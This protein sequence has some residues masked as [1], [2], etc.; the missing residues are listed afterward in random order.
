MTAIQIEHHYQQPEFPLSNTDM[1][2]Q[3]ESS[4]PHPVVKASQNTFAVDTSIRLLWAVHMC[5]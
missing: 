4:S 5:I 2:P 3:V 1:I